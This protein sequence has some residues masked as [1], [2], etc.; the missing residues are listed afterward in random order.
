MRIN[1]YYSQHYDAINFL[2]KYGIELNIIVNES[3]FALAQ[4]KPNIVIHPKSFILNGEY[5]T[6]KFMGPEC[7]F[8]NYKY[9]V[10][11]GFDKESATNKMH[12]IKSQCSFINTTNN[13]DFIKKLES[14]FSLR[15]WGR[16]VDSLSYMGP[17]NCNTYEIYNS[18]EVCAA[19]N[20]SE[21]LKATYV[22]KF[23]YTP[24]NYL[25]GKFCLTQNI[26]EANNDYARIFVNKDELF[27]LKDWRVI[28][29]EIFEI[30]G[31]NKI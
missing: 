21:I 22:G 1:S 5:P 16:P 7:D 24:F 23:C 15:V 25:G 14:M 12:P 11:F 8:P 18:S 4:S 3:P 27:E 29:N 31:E 20:E 9:L 26:F 2:K 10:N 17:I 19:D 30:C 28:F 6:I 13:I